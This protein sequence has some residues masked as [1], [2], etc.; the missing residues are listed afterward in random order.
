MN[1]DIKKFANHLGYTD[2]NP[3]EVVNIVS[4]IT[5]EIRAMNT[6]Q[7]VFPKQFE[8][9]GFSAHC[10]DN[11][12]QKYEYSSCLESPVFRIRWSKAKNTWQ[13]PGGMRFQM[14]DKPYKF[15]DYNF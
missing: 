1:K 10:S 12:N 14:D 5:V 9:G 11:H 3:F 2:V 8:V 6:K 7:I 13:R 15:Y 4:P